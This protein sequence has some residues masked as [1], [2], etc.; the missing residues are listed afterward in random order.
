MKARIPKAYHSL[1]KSQQDGLREYAKEIALTAAEEQFNKDLRIV[2]DLY[3]K[4][5]CVIMH[6]TEGYGERRLNRILWNH[7]RTFRR[8]ARMVKDGTQIEYLNRRMAEIFK[9]DGFPQHYFDE[10]L[11]EVEYDTPK[12]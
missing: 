4:M 11:G 6:D 9:K 8:Q 7:K 2:L 3:T 1:P 12:I 10:M 5:F